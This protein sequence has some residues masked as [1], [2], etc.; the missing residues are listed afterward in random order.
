MAR[1]NGIGADYTISYPIALTIIAFLA[2]AFYNVIELTLSI[3]TT[4]KR[5]SGLY[6]WSLV[7]ATWGIIPYGLGFFLKFYPVWPPTIFYLTLIAIGWPCMITGQSLVLYSRLHLI[8]RSTATGARWVLWMIIFNATICH[9]PIIVLLYGAN[10][11]HSAPY[12]TPYSVYEKVQITIFF[13]QEVIISGIYLFKTKELLRT[14]GGIRGRNARKVIIHLVWVN[15]LI[16][17]LD[18]TLLAIEYAGYY[19]IQTTYKAAVYSVKLKMEFA[20]LNRL[21]DLFQGKIHDSSSD[22]SSRSWTTSGFGK[23]IKKSSARKSLPVMVPA[24]AHPGSN[25]GNSAYAR[26]EED[27]ITPASISLKDM[28]V[29]K[30]TEVRIERSDRLPEGDIA[31]I[32]I[33]SLAEHSWRKAHRS[34]STASSEVDIA[35]NGF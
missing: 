35:R 31:D 1:D 16:I 25:L 8:L 29:M 2:V 22:P 9:V 24:G 17:I 15:V 12:L 7:I 11:N 18:I 14:E 34:L 32:E 30:T 19:D 5:R 26:M 10:S 4:F 27:G 6:F 21:L 20:I 33:G 23:S 13:I 28:E 3:F